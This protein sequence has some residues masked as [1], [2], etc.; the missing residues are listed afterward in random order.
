MRTE[1]HVREALPKTFEEQESVY[2]RAAKLLGL[3]APVHSEI[4]LVDRLEKGLSVHAVWSLRARAQLTDEEIYGLI[5]PRRTLNRRETERQP[6]SADEADRA[7]R[8]ARVV[9]RAQQMFSG[10][11]TYAPEWLR[12]PQHALGDRSPLQVLSRESGAR[13]VEEILLGLEHGIF[14]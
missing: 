7:V 3:T 1:H 14:A 2:E 6:L 4:E 9:A 11:R 8:I 13:A 12:T 5:A 10:K